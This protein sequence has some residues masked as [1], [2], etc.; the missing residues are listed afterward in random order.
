M[1]I[2]KHLHVEAPPEACVVGP[3]VRKCVPD[4]PDTAAG[5]DN[6][7]SHTQAAMLPQH[8]LSI[9]WVPEWSLLHSWLFALI[10]SK[11][12]VPCCLGQPPTTLSMSESISLN[13][14][15]CTSEGE[16]H[17]VQ[18]SGVPPAKTVRQTSSQGTCS[19]NNL[20]FWPGSRQRV[21]FF[22]DKQ[23]KS[24]FSFHC[25]YL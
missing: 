4:V 10:K 15:K 20:S 11:D 25:A 23:I 19:G 6:S 8:K 2:Y 1:F 12:I 13:S 5:Y 7:P 14:D 24:F 16:P 17:L 22:L 9:C 18:G 3:G 21:K